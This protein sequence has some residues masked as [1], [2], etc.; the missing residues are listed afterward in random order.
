[1][2]D[3]RLGR[4]G[5]EICIC[6]IAQHRLY[7]HPLREAGLPKGVQGQAV[8]RQLLL[9]LVECL[10]AHVAVF[11]H[12]D[13]SLAGE[14]LNGNDALAAK[15][16][17]RS[18]GQV[19]GFD[20]LCEYLLLVIQCER[21]GV[22]QQLPDFRHGAPIAVQNARVVRGVDRSLVVFQRNEALGC[23]IL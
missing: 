7:S 13:L 8:C 10:P 22:A 5:C 4:R 23:F 12:F 11:R 19:K 15:D 1:M 17:E 18:N 6:A 14:V 21:V 3:E 20:R 2:I 16:V 9:D